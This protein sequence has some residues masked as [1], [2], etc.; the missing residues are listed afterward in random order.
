M[1]LPFAASGRADDAHVHVDGREKQHEA[2]RKLPKSLPRQ[3]PQ[4]ALLQSALQRSAQREEGWHGGQVTPQRRDERRE[5]RDGGF[6]YRLSLY[7]TNTKLLTFVR[8]FIPA[9]LPLKGVLP[10]RRHHTFLRQPEQRY[11]TL[12]FASKIV[13]QQGAARPYWKPRV[14]GISP[15]RI[16]HILT[17]GGTK[18]RNPVWLPCYQK[19]KTRINSL[20]QIGVI[21]FFCA[22]IFSSNLQISIL[23]L[24]R[25]RDEVH[26]M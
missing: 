23:T 13:C 17:A 3:P 11:N 6:I 1:G 16:P 2:L 22:W 10:I 8:S 9:L 26:M 20:R 18:L 21:P 25:G 14:K 24:R 19:S 12:D 4:R 7:R 5:T 15:L